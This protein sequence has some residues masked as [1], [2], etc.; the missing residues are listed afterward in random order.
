MY[1]HAHTH[2][3]T[4]TYT[5]THVHIYLKCF[6][7]SYFHKTGCWLSGD[8]FSLEILNFYF[9]SVIIGLFSETKVFLSDKQILPVSSKICEL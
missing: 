7:H 8:K 4:H 6:Y 1:T 2:T 9:F 5:R 3:H